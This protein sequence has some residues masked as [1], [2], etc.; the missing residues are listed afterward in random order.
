M[1]IFEEGKYR[2][3]TKQDTEG[4]LILATLM[5]L[6]ITGMFWLVWKLI[7]TIFI[8]LAFA[9]AWIIGNTKNKNKNNKN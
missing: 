4:D 9:F 5:G 8:S 2:K 6:I 3:A 1:Y 7:S